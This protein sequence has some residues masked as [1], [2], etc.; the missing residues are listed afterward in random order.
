MLLSPPS[1]YDHLPAP[2]DDAQLRLGLA[3]WQETAE[4]SD[5]ALAAAMQ[6]LAAEPAGHR[7]LAAL[8]GNSPFLTQCCLKEPDFLL[9]LVQQGPDT[10]FA[11]LDQSLNRHFPTTED[12]HG[13]MRELRIAKQ[14]AA[15]LVAIADIAGWWPLARVTGALSTIAAAAL[16]RAVR[17]L[18]AAAAAGGEI[19]LAHP[20]RS[21]TAASSYSAWASLAPASLIIQATST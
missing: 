21:P 18:L 2:A 5:A 8:F 16:G 15:L 1:A 17:H 13:L 20:S 6:A 14:R 19:E 3:H 10:I 4:T 7:L 11:E 9:R 12:Q